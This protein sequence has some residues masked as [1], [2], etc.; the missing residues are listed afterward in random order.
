MPKYSRKRNAPYFAFLA[1]KRGRRKGDE[2]KGGKSRVFRWNKVGYTIALLTFVRGR[3]VASR[4]NGLVAGGN[5]RECD[6]HFSRFFRVPGKSARIDGKSGEKS[7]EI[8][9]QHRRS[10][11][12]VLR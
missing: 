3:K 8:Q 10:D 6:G 1:P 12:D 7:R 2:K 4:S 11:S 9:L 5:A